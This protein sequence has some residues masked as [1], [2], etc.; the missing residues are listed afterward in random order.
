MNRANSIGIQGR[1][2]LFNFETPVHTRDFEK[3][4][5]TYAAEKAAAAAAAAAAKAAAAKKWNIFALY[6]KDL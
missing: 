3:E 2:S 6:L 1:T 5:E 4:K